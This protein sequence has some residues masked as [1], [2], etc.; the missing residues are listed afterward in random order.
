MK[1]LFKVLSIFLVINIMLSYFPLLGNKGP[2]FAAEVEKKYNVPSNKEWTI[3]FNMEVDKSTVNTSNIK[4]HEKNSTYSIPINITLSSDLKEVK[5]KPTTP[6]TH[7]KTYV[8]ELNDKIKSK[9]GKFNLSSYKLEFNAVNNVFA[10]LPSEDGL[11]IVEDI[12]YSV[13]YL[14]KNNYVTNEI[15]KNGVYDFYYLYDADYQRIS[16]LFSTDY[17]SHTGNGSVRKY[18]KMTYID[19]NGKK[20]IYEWDNKTYEFKEVLPKL[21]VYITVKSSIKAISFK[22]NK[23]Y[24]LP[25]AK[26]YKLKHS[27]FQ[28][29]LS[30]T[31]TYTSDD[32]WDEVYI[33]SGDGRTIAKGFFEANWSGSKSVYL[34]LDD[35]SSFGT[36]TGNSNNNGIASVDNEGYIYYSNPADNEKLYKAGYDGAYNKK[37]SED[38]AQY[39]N[40]SNGW[41]YYS[42]YSDG[43]KI[44]KVKTD[45][46]SREKI[47]DVKASYLTLYGDNIYFCN[48]S[49]GGKIYK[50]SRYGSGLS[51]LPADTGEAAYL[52]I[53]GDYIYYTNLSDG[54]KPYVVSLDGKFRGK[55]W[56]GWADCLQVVGNYMYFSSGTGVISKISKD[57]YG[58]VIPILAE[59]KL[60]NKGHHINVFGDY[61]YY[62]NVL[63]KGKLYRIKTDG[64]GEKI[65]LSDEDTGYINILNGKLIFN[66]TK[67][68]IFSLPLDSDGNEKPVEL[69][70][71]KIT[72]KIKY[73]EDITID[74]PYYDA[75]T[76]KE[77]LEKKYLPDKVS[78]IFQDNTMHQIVVSWDKEKAILRN[79]VY[80]YKGNLVGYNKTINLYMNILSEMLNDTNKIMINNNPGRYDT[81]E[82]IDTGSGTGISLNQGD[83][84][85]V[86]NDENCKKLLGKATVGKDRKALVRGIDLD[87]T[88]RSFYITVKRGQKGESK[89]TMIKQPD[90]PNINPS[91]AADNDF[92]GFELD[93]RDFTLNKWIKPRFTGN[94]DI[95]LAKQYIY[96]LPSR[97]Q[98]DM[99]NQT[100]FDEI[101]LSYSGSWTGQ[102]DKI[103]DSKQNLF[104]N[105]SYAIYVSVEFSGYGSADIQGRKPQISGQISSENPGNLT[106]VS[107]ILPN[108]INI[109]SMKVQPET[110]ITL[111]TAPKPGETVWIAPAGLKW[112]AENGGIE[113]V[114]KE[115]NEVTKLVGDGTSKIIIAPSKPNS[116]SNPYKVYVTNS[117]GSSKESSGSI[118]VEGDSP[119]VTTSPANI[120]YIFV[121]NTL[122]VSSSK[123]GKVYLMSQDNYKAQ[124]VADLEQAVKDKQANFV[125]IYSNKIYYPLSSAGLDYYTIN[126]NFILLA[127]D[128]AGNISEPVNISI[129]RDTSELEFYIFKAQCV[130][131]E[132][133]KIDPN[134]AL[135]LKL[136][137]NSAEDLMKNNTKATTY[138]I[139]KAAKDLDFATVKY[140]GTLAANQWQDVYNARESIKEK[141][142]GD[143]LIL[144]GVK[145][146]II[147][148]KKDTTEIRMPKLADDPEFKNITINWVSDN[149][150][151]KIEDMGT[152]VKGTVTIPEDIDQHVTI[153]AVITKLNDYGAPIASIRR[154]EIITVK[155]K[156]NQ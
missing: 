78:A 59:A 65:K 46:S 70:V 154:Y 98:L 7:N 30:E 147:S 28:R 140:G 110:P 93:G 115:S 56:D 112:M 95:S 114:F 153:T 125:N 68:K 2:A 10:G 134:K 106:V 71:T 43:G 39:I 152:Y 148:S 149:E 8:L 144:N 76:S 156:K 23:I 104:K 17:D 27:D 16:K 133:I 113:S 20:H 126:N 25:D 44:Y 107:E 77:Y 130:V 51:K 117:V 48:H 128:E 40:V 29:S 123:R 26:Y 6:Y 136:A 52:N 111:P 53:I 57:G 94:S 67:N 21:D 88:G 37:I 1:K 141:I 139:D 122:K 91:D 108:P 42:N 90:A 11:I 12:A 97:T 49:D 143:D 62:G 69:G 103:K 66:T 105:G 3:K 86:Y 13:K 150:I 19:G 121:G 60:Y 138:Q 155:A 38:K 145:G 120:E 109:A 79:G 119:Y 151:I 131:D 83:I 124:T 96:I 61:I 54:H 135:N 75:N 72:D 22:I 142:T 33:L 73:A 84:I 18:N 47:A 81:I 80:T 127:A 34:N 82:I 35:E 31:A 132:L 15:I 55:V 64:S 89:A 116:S 87:S 99:M 32:Y 63:D 36:T 58:P 118:I 100:T 129:I 45:G 101:P 14:E 24:G 9:D 74:I 146:Y 102:K 85:S 92:V 137:I 4:V 50:V 5:I 41:I